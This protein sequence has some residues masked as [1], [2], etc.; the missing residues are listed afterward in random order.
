MKK[1]MAAASL[2]MIPMLTMNVNAENMKTGIV[3]SSYLNVRYS[4]SASGK[5]QLVLKKGNKVNVI[6]EKDGWYKVRTASGK[7]GWVVSK[8]ISLKADAIRKDS[9]SIKKIVI[10]T[11]LNVRS[12]PDTSYTSIGKLYKNNEVDVISESNGWSKIQFGS[13][14]GYVSSEYLKAVSTGNDNTGSTD[15]SNGP[16]RTIQEVTSS[17]LNVRNGAGGKY[18]KIDTLHK[19]D[20]V[21]VSTIENNWAKV[22]Y[23]GKTGY[24]SSIYLKYVSDKIEDDNAG[25]SGGTASD[26]IP[27]A[28]MQRSKKDYSLSDM[29]EA[30]YIKG[31]AGGNLISR[32]MNRMNLGLFDNMD[33]ILFNPQDN[34]FTTSDMRA[35]PR[36]YNAPTKEELE[37]YL[38]PS[39]FTS[40]KDGIMQFV[41]LDRY[42][43]SITAKSLDN[44]FASRGSECIFNGM[45]QAFIDSAKKYDIDVLYFVSHAMWETGN[46]KSTLA[47]G[48]LVTN[49]ENGNP[50]ETP[51]KVYNFFGIGATD[52]N[53]LEGG[54][55]TAYKNGWTSVEKG[56]DGAAKWISD[57]YIH[58]S[59]YKQNTVYSMRWCYEYTWHQYATDVNW[60]NG[61]S[62]MMS[63]LMTKYGNGNN[64]LIDIPEY[65]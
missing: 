36:A 9:R 48:Q 2:A 32:N 41:R 44:Y 33:G 18:T 63:S 37:Y 11:T 23:D 10:A 62:K 3:S 19:G 30:Q 5:L 47:K 4:P 29:V 27:G 46:G 57:G 64:L 24:V 61:I 51:V 1:R 50:L 17:L 7:T 53:A 25:A 16:K 15:N 13:K 52:G 6:G 31:Q 14:I 42:T 12:G 8:Y 21:I 34:S 45:G 28:Y 40:Y 60:A 26:I 49:D 54:K 43:D 58:N 59:N 20:K 38:D 55:M 22:E 39:N 65:K 35:N 56:I